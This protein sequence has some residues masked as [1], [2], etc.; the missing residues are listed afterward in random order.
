M[1][2]ILDGN[3]TDL[4]R[5]PIVIRNN[6]ISSRFF[7]APINTGFSNKGVP[8][9]RLLKFHKDRSG[10]M[11]GISYVGNVA[12]DA[13]FVSNDRTNVMQKDVP[14]YKDLSQQILRAGSIPGIQLA[15]NDPF[16]V[17]QKEW[18]NINPRSY[19]SDASE[20]ISSL[21][22]SK[23]LE[24]IENYVKAAKLA[25]D[26]GFVVIQIHAAHGYFLS[27]LL[28]VLNKR[29]DE[30]GDG[31]FVV[32]EIIRKVR[33]TVPD[34]ILDLRLNL[35]DGIEDKEKE[36]KSRL[37]HLEKLVGLEV[38][39]I[40]L[41]RGFYN[42]NKHLIYPSPKEGHGC[43][44]NE[45]VYLAKKY[46]QK[47]WNMAGNI[48]DVELLGKVIPNNLTFSLGR[49]LIADPYFVEKSFTG[50]KRSINRCTLCGKCH[51]YSLGKKHISCGKNSL[52]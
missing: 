41:S 28:S 8:S 39:L 26:Y 52:I 40:S 29:T 11:I 45:T 47:S 36:I 37:A 27:Q 16:I 42:L 22:A 9:A 48:W 24:I 7:L 6:N 32:K 17:A 31:L 46:E 38:D 10:K 21:G 5:A 35:Y 30:Y 33:L 13:T 1:R 44:L 43:I 15:C 14:F 4:L 19:L 12:I 51:Y 23:F 25:Y 3:K 49:A 34:V 2:H 18:V 20:R 50:L